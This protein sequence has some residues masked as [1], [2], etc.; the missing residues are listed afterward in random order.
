MGQTASKRL[1]P[2][3]PTALIP[4]SVRPV[5]P[6]EVQEP[7]IFN[8]LNNLITSNNVLDTRIVEKPGI[9]AR[10]VKPVVRVDGSKYF[11]PGLLKEGGAV[12]WK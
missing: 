12:V 4:P 9:K 10:I 6:V 5:P 8:S 3:T 7:L 11:N 1:L 2:K